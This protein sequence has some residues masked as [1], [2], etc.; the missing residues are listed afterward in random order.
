MST[1]YPDVTVELTGQDGN[2]MM[3]MALTQKAM[4]RA[5]VPKEELDAY[6]K[7]ATSGDYTNVLVTTMNW[8]N[9]E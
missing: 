9:V 5:G 6:F 7:E 2:A 1:K 4:R 8:V 3:I